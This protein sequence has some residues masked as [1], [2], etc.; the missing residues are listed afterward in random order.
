MFCWGDG[1]AAQLPL[2]DSGGHGPREIEHLRDRPVKEVSCGAKHSVFLLTDGTVYTCGQNES[3]QLGRKTDQSA[4]DQID[5]LTTITIV[6]VACGK[7]HTLA[8]GENGS[9]FAW[10]AGSYGQLGREDYP[11]CAHHPRKVKFEVPIAQ[12]RCGHYH[13]LALSQDGTVYSWGLNTYGQ[14]GNGKDLEK[15]SRP[16]RVRSLTGIPV[17]LIAAG[18]SHSFA[19]SLSGAVYGWGRNEHGQLGLK[20]KADREIPYS[21]DQ[22]RR[23]NVA[24]ISCGSHHSVVLTKDGA[25][26]TCGDGSSG[27]LGLGRKG[28]VTSFQRVEQIKDEVSQVACGSDH[29]L[30]YIPCSDLVVSFGLGNKGKTEKDSSRNQIHQESQHAKVNKIFAGPNINFIQTKLPIPAADL[31]I[32]AADLRCR[33]SKEQMLILDATIAER[34]INVDEYDN[35]ER[36]H[37]KREIG[38]IF[39]SSSC[40]VGS[41]L[42]KSEGDLCKTGHN[43]VSVDVEAAREIFKKL[44]A[45]DWI[46]EVIKSSLT[47]KLIQ[48]LERLGSDEEALMIYLILPECQV[49]Q[50]DRDIVHGF[51]RAMAHLDATSKKTL[52]EHWSTLESSYLNTMVKI[53]K[54][55]LTR[56]IIDLFHLCQQ[57]HP[58]LTQQ[59]HPSFTHRFNDQQTELKNVLDVLE[60]VYKANM[61][62]KHSI[63][64]SNF[65]ISE[66]RLFRFDIILTYRAE[67]LI[68]ITL[69]FLSYPFVLDLLYKAQL[70]YMDSELKMKKAAFDAFHFILRNSLAGSPEPPRN[71]WFILKVNRQSLVA[72]TFEILKNV[73]KAELQKPLLVEFKGEPGVN[74]EAIKKEFFVSV[75]QRLVHPDSKMF[76]HLQGL[77]SIWLPSQV[78]LP[79]Q[80]YF[81]LGVLCSLVLYNMCVISIPL[82][83]A[84]FKKLLNIKPTLE[85]VLE[86]ERSLHKTLQSILNCDKVEDLELY[87]TMPWE[88]RDVDVIPNGRNQPLTNKNREKFVEACLNYIFKT[89]IKKPFD[90]FRRGFYHVLDEKLIKL[91]QPEELKDML[92]G[93]IEYDWQILEENTSY[94]GTYHRTHPTIKIFWEVFHQMVLDEKKLFLS[95]VTGSPQIPVMGL[96][97]IEIIISSC[98]LTENDYPEAMNCYNTLYLPEYTSSESLRTKLVAAIN[99][100]PKA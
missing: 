90:E 9:V 34:W 30:A 81:L 84:L 47:S 88:G 79:I 55:F 57:L 93:S 46:L 80:D 40:L 73:N 78:S 1:L 39:S 77:R 6:N 94:K 59:L 7:D 97:C 4:L 58:Q 29:T 27:Q 17:A 76:I 95:F 12:I 20:D 99:T 56:K 54:T 14:L 25:V 43:L 32:P 2:L 64:L 52:G 36:I 13:S 49:M 45:K 68:N 71:T 37:A 19:L 10:G 69:M 11:I 50:K 53:I 82:P 100:F 42:K 38:L 28:N 91:F 98:E 44:T 65:Y 85:D 63:P 96:K 89:S 3:G 31:P 21:V 48:H 16:Q 22:L 86:V 51:V 92:I 62:L 66:L 70:L 87:C 8:L 18:G 83:L 24:Y 23:L 74:L 60:L 15:Q 41:F 67:Q 35:E 5:S 26:F 72:D 33:D 61:K 75:F